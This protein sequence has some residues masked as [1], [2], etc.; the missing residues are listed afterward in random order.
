MC[1]GDIKTLL[2]NKP[3]IALAFLAEEYKIFYFAR[4]CKDML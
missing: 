3:V 2:S 4:F 1:L